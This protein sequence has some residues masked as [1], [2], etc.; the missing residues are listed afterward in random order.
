M[1]ARSSPVRLFM[2]IALAACMNLPMLAQDE[3][4]VPDDLPGLSLQRLTVNVTSSF[5]F[6][7]W[8]DLN[9][10][11]GAVRDAYAYNP[12]LGLQSGSVDRHRGDMSAGLDLTYRLVGPISAT[13]EGSFTTTGAEMHLTTAPGNISIA[14]VFGPREFRNTFDLSLVGI[15]AGFVIDLSGALNTR[16]RLTAGH[17]SATLDYFFHMNSAYENS[18]LDATL[19]DE[20]TYISIGIENSITIAGPLSF[21]LGAHYR[22]LRFANLQGDGRAFHALPFMS[23]HAFEVPIKARL[24]RA[25]SYYGVDGPED[26]RVNM[27]ERSML[28]PWLVTPNVNIYSSLQEEAV[29]A[30]LYLNGF[31]IKGGLT[32]AF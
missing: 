3:P 13:I 10:S 6:A 21:F 8:K 29:P 2:L 20:G 15:G 14:G 31:G 5:V 7:P 4:P 28:G 12:I 16:L 32:Y 1:R 22:S 11:F 26:W 25:G 23:G 9:D 19:R 17:S 27:V 18:R 30:T 24:V